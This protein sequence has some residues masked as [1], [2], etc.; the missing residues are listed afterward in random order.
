MCWHIRGSMQGFYIEVKE[1][2]A[3]TLHKLVG[4][5]PQTNQP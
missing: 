4:E 5:F 1:V 2:R 3:G